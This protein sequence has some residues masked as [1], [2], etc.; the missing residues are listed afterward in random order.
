MSEKIKKAFRGDSGKLLET[1]RKIIPIA[2]LLILFLIFSVSTGGKFLK[3]NNLRT[4]IMQSAITMVAAVGTA[5]VMS[6]NNLDFS[7]GGACALSCVLAYLIAGDNLVLF[8]LL[9]V[10]FGVL[11]GLFSAFLHIKGQIPA[12]MA[13]VCLMFAGRGVAQGVSSN[14]TMMLIEAAEYNN[15]AFIMIV[16]A[17]VIIVGFILFNYTK[18]GK[19]QKLI[20]TNPKASELSGINVSRYKTIAFAISGATLGIAACLT[21]IRSPSIVGSTGTNLET[22][23]LLALCLGGMSMTGGSSSKIRSA[24]IGTLIFFI[25]NNGLTLWGVDANYVDIIRAVFFLATVAISTDRTQTD[26]IT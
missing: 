3:I 13:G 11:C 15:F 10:V 16:L 1:V 8:F 14:H 7:L 24:I 23:V 21:V 26:T 20:G 2:G 12:F 25:L 19:Y 4:L 22:N 6:H 9:C 17:V 5:F 18:I